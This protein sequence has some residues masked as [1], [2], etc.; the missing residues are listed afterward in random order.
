MGY[1]FS[2]RD[3]SQVISKSQVLPQYHEV[4]D[5]I[6]SK[7]GNT[8]EID[9]AQER[10]LFASE[11]NKE[12]KAGNIT[13]NQYKNMTGFVYCDRELVDKYFEYQKHRDETKKE[14]PKPEYK[15]YDPRGWF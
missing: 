6:A 5:N 13:P 9:T 2:V 14:E 10:N 8:D 12:V 7:G 4:Y 3:I 11:M 1:S 15:W